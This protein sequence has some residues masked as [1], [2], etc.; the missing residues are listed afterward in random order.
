ML[1]SGLYQLLSAVPGVTSLLGVPS[2]AQGG[3]QA[4]YFSVAPKQPAVPFLV[5]HRK[6]AKPAGQT[7]DGPSALIDAELQFDSYANDQVTAQKISRAVRT[8]LAG[9]SMALPD[10]TIIQFY[11]VTADMDGGYEQGDSSY[12]YRAILCLAAMYTEGS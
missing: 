9:I 10:N 4:I 8:A 12:L 11:E 1:V 3:G 2:A 7:F 5:I 6:D